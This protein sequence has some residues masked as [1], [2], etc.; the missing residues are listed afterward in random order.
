MRV[1]DVEALIHFLEQCQ[2]ITG[3]EMMTLGSCQVPFLL[4]NGTK[5]TRELRK[6]T[7]VQIMRLDA[8]AAAAKTD[9]KAMKLIWSVLICGSLV[10]VL[11]SV[12][13]LEG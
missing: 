2:N 7:L 8:G 11:A 4:P 9:E 13:A 6:L 3:Q 10:L 5:I 1:P 12:Q